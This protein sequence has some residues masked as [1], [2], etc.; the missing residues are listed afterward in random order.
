M[1]DDQDPVLRRLF[2]EPAPTASTDEFMLKLGQRLDA[3]QRLRGVYRLLAIVA[4]LVVSVLSAPWL[5]QITSTL[6]ELAAVGPGANGFLHAPLTW[7][8]VV[9]TVAGCLPVIYLWRTGRW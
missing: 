2:A 4:C 5:A 6:I 3:R 8:V 1:N 9:A 7:S